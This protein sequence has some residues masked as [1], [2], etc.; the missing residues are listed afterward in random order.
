MKAPQLKASTA[1]LQ[2]R[3]ITRP[4]RGGGENLKFWIFSQRFF[5]SRVRFNVSLVVVS[6]SSVPLR[7]EY[8][9]VGGISP[10]AWNRSPQASDTSD[11]FHTISQDG[12][13]ARQLSARASGIER[14]PGLKPLVVNLSDPTIRWESGGDCCSDVNS[15]YSALHCLVDPP[16]RRHDS[17]GTLGF[18]LM[19]IDRQIQFP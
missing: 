10:N 16:M 2:K 11:R 14:S 9:F 8:W 5:S 7:E 3:L 19:L 4:R 18:F 13:I 1:L 17:H 15:Y 12:R 6:L